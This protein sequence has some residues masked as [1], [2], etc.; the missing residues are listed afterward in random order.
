MPAAKPAAKPAAAGRAEEE[1]GAIGVSVKSQQSV[2]RAVIAVFLNSY[3]RGYRGANGP[4]V[5]RGGAVPG[6]AA[7]ARR[8]AACCLTRDS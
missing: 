8:A 5:R 3:R 1:L 2:A 4:C 7:A 6:V